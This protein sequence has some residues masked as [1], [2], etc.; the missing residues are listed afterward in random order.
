M[1]RGVS[2]RSIGVQWVIVVCWRTIFANLFY[3]ARDFNTQDLA[4]P[5][6]G[7]VMSLTLIDIHS[8]ECECLH[9]QI[10]RRQYIAWLSLVSICADQVR[11][12]PWLKFEYLEEWAW[13][14]LRYT[15]RSR[16]LLLQQITSEPTEHMSLCAIVHIPG[17]FT[18]TAFMDM[19]AIKIC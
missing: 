6:R 11:S 5:R 2:T 3:Y 12:L 7:R 16:R 13:G 17:A 8:V 1:Q 10:T 14:S 9:L 18:W 15:S 19:T 4:G